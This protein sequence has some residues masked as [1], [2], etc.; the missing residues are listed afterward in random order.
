MLNH[1]ER[2]DR[3]HC[4]LV[5]R[6]DPGQAA[7]SNSRALVVAFNTS[8]ESALVPTTSYY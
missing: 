4:L 3:L 2:G 8:D 5:N 1:V 6:H 7:L